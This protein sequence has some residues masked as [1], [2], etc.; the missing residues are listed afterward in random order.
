MAGL[1][2]EYV[3]DIDRTVASAKAEGRFD[4]AEYFTLRATNDAIREKGASWL[5]DTLLEI[6]GAFNDNGAGIAVEDT[7]SHRFRFNGSWL[8]G[9][10]VS[11]RRGVRKLTV[12]AGWTQ[13]TG[14]GIMRGGALVCAKISHFGLA[15]ETEEL[16]LLKID[17]VP[18]W[19]IRTGERELSTFNVRSFKRHFELFLG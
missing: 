12:E 14:D 17:D 9:S 15:N 2:E 11:L 4:L 7:G 18:Q 6:V 3:R 5:F 10:A 8:S 13:S 16:L 1:D 19:F